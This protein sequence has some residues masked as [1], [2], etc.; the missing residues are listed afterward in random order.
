MK[1]FNLTIKDSSLAFGV[2]FILC[3]LAVVIVSMIAMFIAVMFG[4]TD[5]SIGQFN[6][7]AV[8]YL[9][10]AVIMYATILCIFF[11]FK[12][13]TDS[14]IFKTPSAKKSLIYALIAVISFLTLY[15][16]ITCIDSVFVHFGIEINSLDY[17]LDTKNYFISLISL[18]ILP[19]ICEELLFRGVIFGGLKKGGK[20]FSILVTGI[21]FG[22]FHMSIT[23]TIYPLLMGILFSLVMYREDNLIYPIIMHTIN[24]F[25]S[26][27][28]SYFGINL[29]FQHWTY[30]LLACVLALIFI[31]TILTLS[32]LGNKE[33]KKEKFTTEECVYFTLSISIMLII[34]LT[35]N[36]S[37][38]I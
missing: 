29:I 10:S 2:G 3:Q 31:S 14:K 32:I 8:G 37:I 22:I 5:E 27:T 20:T 17:P 24:N 7:S 30:I 35:Y 28:L 18:V 25:L 34:W 23:Q 11:F 26:L 6:S 13:K 38:I 1:K 12:R 4:A 33:S 16:V 9:L 21:M 36:I 15:P 19:A